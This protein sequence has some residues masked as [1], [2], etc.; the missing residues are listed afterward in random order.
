MFKLSSTSR[1]LLALGYSFCTKSATH[2]ICKIRL[3]P[4]AGHFY[5][6]L[7]SHRFYGHK[8]VS[9]SVALIFILELLPTDPASWGSACVCWAFLFQ[10]VTA[11]ENFIAVS[12]SDS[13]PSRSIGNGG[14][15]VGMCAKVRPTIQ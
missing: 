8:N 1:I 11:I 14:S 13:Y 15:P 3:L 10:G 12:Y 2:K 7:A 6:P 4:R 5:N 9:C